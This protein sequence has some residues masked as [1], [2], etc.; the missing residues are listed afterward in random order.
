MDSWKNEVLSAIYKL[1][2]TK[3]ILNVDFLQ[4]FLRIVFKKCRE[5]YDIAIKDMLNEEDEGFKAT[6]NKMYPIAILK[7][8]IRFLIKILTRLYGEQ[9]P[10]HYKT[11]WIPII[12]NI[13]NE[14][15]CLN[16]V[17]ILSQNITQSLKLSLSYPL[18]YKHTF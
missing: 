8:P 12:H 4:N 17:E 11:K 5:N 16:L 7:N 2:P 6:E 15:K 13:L 9:D 18:G 3:I 1:N 14:G 10:Q